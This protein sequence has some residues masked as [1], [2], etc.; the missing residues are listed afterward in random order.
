MFN[1]QLRD[2]G[3][4]IEDRRTLMG[5]S[6]SRTTEV[7]GRGNLELAVEYLNRLEKYSRIPALI[8]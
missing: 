8:W 7:Y 1:N 2:L 5:H 4:G 3:L 6:A